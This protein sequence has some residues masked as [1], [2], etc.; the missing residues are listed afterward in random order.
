MDEPTPSLA[1]A[2]RGLRPISNAI[3]VVLLVAG[4]ASTV[5]QASSSPT[6]APAATSAASASGP[7]SVAPLSG[8]WDGALEDPSGVWPARL[9]LDGCGTV[10]DVCGGLEYLP[11]D[12]LP[13]ATCASDLT[14]Q[15]MEGAALVLSETMVY[16]PW[17]CFATT[18]RVRPD[19]T[20]GLTVE[21]VVDDGS[22]CCR[23][24][25][26]RVGAADM[27]EDLPELGAVEGIG[28]AT[29]VV[30]L[31]G[32]S[33]QYTTST[34]GSVWLPLDNVGAVAQV[35]AETGAL[36]ATLPTGGDPG[37]VT[38]LQTDPHSVAADGGVVWV[39]QAAGH[40]VAPLDAATGSLGASIP[41]DAAPYAL[42]IDGS[43]L[44]ATSFLDDA[45]VRIDLATSK[46]VARITASKPTGI[47]VGEG[48]VW[49]VL[50]R[51][52][53]IVRIDPA[54]NK[55]AATIVLTPAGPSDL[56]GRCVEN[57]VVADSAVWTADNSA[58]AVTRIDP[59]T[60]KVT[61]TITLPHRV[62]AVAAGGGSIWA[63]QFESITEG[64]DAATDMGIAR[65][66]P[67]TNAVTIAAFPV[68]SVS[69]GAD[70]LWA[71]G[72]SRR[73]DLLYRIDVE[74]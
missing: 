48:G 10:G 15:G 44:W 25:F 58:R 68:F 32:T 8:T 56:C 66:D 23:G 41:I 59:A 20:D 73:G 30:S 27:G 74:K 61:A 5:P 28:R 55:V 29:S 54:T 37:A 4:C 40:S 2:H 35:D 65:I 72:P 18:L 3:L 67:A 31:G 51:S 17:K 71:L 52:D 14:Y 57:I 45:V 46:V 11:P 49:V 47:A 24:A 60:N 42:A 50:H 39:A 16:Q 70:A 34:D 21:Q 43:T 69:W 6:S 7:P 12:G 1:R 19:T 36:V 9:I 62:W 38:D 53:T 26:D 63:S 33:T 22:V 64:G 13:A